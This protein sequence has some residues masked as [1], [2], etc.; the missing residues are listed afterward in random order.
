MSTPEWMKKFEQIGQ[1][2]QEEVTAV[3]NDG[4]MKTNTVEPRRSFDFTNNTTKNTD[5]DVPSQASIAHSGASDVARDKVNSDDENDAAALFLGAA[6]TRSPGGSTRSNNSPDPPEES[7]GSSEDDSSNGFSADDANTIPSSGYVSDG[8]NGVESSGIP[9]A[10][11]TNKDE[12]FGESWV[13][14]QDKLKSRG[15]DDVDSEGAGGLSRQSSI[16]ESFVTEEV[17]VDE[18]GNEIVLDE[19]G[20]EMQVDESGDEIQVDE[21]GDEIQEVDESG[22][23]IQVD[24]S[25][26][27]IQVDENGDEIQEVDESGDE[28]QVDENGDEIQEVDESDDE[29]QVDEIGDEIEVDENGDEIRV[30]ENGDEVQIDENGDEIQ[31]EILIDESVQDFSPHQE[32]DF[33]RDVYKPVSGENNR[34][35][36]IER[37][38]LPSGAPP[39]YDIEEQRRILGVGKTGNRSRMSWCIPILV[40][41]IIVASIL[42]VIFLVVY[43]EDESFY[44]VTPTMAPIAANYLELEPTASSSGSIDAAA[45]TEFDAIRNDCS[46]DLL[47][48]VQPNIVDQ[49]NCG[50]GNVDIIADDVRARWEV[51]VQNFIPSIYSQWDLPSYSCS[52]ENKA[53]LWMSSGINNGGEID[54]LLRLQRYVLALVYYQHGG[55]EWRRSTNWLS[56][57]DVCE[58]GGV[59]CDK[60][61]YVRTLNLD[62][63]R[64]TGQLSNAPTLFNAIE[65][66]F[67]SNNNLIGSIPDAY[68]SDNSLRDIDF[69]GNA[70]S[71]EFSSDISKNSKLTRIN[72]ASNN[73]N[74]PIPRQIGN[75][76]GLES[77]NIESNAFSGILPSS[78]FTLQLTELSIGGNEF[79]GTIPGDI[80]NVSTLTSLS[81]GPNMFTGEIPTSLGELTALKRLS[82]LGIPDLGGRLPASYGLSLINLVELSI[83]D[84]NIEGDIPDL[85]SMMTRLETLRLSNNS[86]R[87]IIPSSLSLLTNLESLSLNGNMLTGT[88]PSKMGLLSSL[89]ELRFDANSLYGTIP[90]EFGNLLMI[91]TLKFDNNFMNGRVPN[92]VCALRDVEL[93]KF[94]V[95]CPTLAGESQVD[96][97][98]CSIPD[99]CTECL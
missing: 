70:L 97:I 56:E 84:T 96:G 76:T 95:D 52:P 62:Q 33:N 71:G 20:N 60:N 50:D 69:S 67:V 21:N 57:I 54:N 9:T 87:G 59:E 25:G 90:D 46:F 98:I 53:L 37:R 26:D 86:I 73:L 64:L 99:C 61:L 92:E 88:I 5:S 45:T 8:Q 72:F 11:T 28:I 18:D 42:L 6:A 15:A 93:N 23:E 82:M 30:D 14:D 34:Y 80:P 40:F 78:L 39:I 12:D 66:Y 17:F 79:K 94:I 43:D 35:G 74:G 1:K 47:G 10:T 51:L 58:W 24:E 13:P 41:V 81:L 48:L 44:G 32:Q 68:F 75:I 63:N 29:I 22:D 27:E 89:Q 77:L 38:T 65:E 85:Y 2:G 55:A 19:N 36:E 83:S 31:E 3:G 91:R 7:S 16:G 49:C 4:F